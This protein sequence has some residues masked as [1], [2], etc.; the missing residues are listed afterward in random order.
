MDVAISNI[1]WS[2][3]DRLPIYAALCDRGVRG[4]EFAPGLLFHDDRDPF[5]PSP[6][7]LRRVRTELDAA[8][9]TLVSMQSLLYGTTDAVLFGDEHQ[10][11]TFIESITRAIGLAGL[12]AVPNLVMGS[13]KNRIR[14]DDMSEDDAD[15]I[16]VDVFRQLGDVAARHGTV[17]ALEPNPAEYGTNFL[18]TFP[19]AKAFRDRVGHPSV[20]VNLDLG[21]LHMTG[22]FGRL[23]EFLQ[24]ALDAV[25]HLHVSRP[26]LSPAPH[27][28][29]EAASIRRAVERSDY[30]GWVSIE[31]RE[32]PDGVTGVLAAVDRILDHPM[33]E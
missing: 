13:P 26:H 12:L 5:A 3:E 25:S 21:A 29:D 18:T 17:L 30:S 28:T 31:M 19:D 9:L 23:D 10:R 16:A 4:L 11:R 15:R 32:P 2:P 6:A 1:A 22:D 33:E 24:G 14:P 8:Q 7:A 20:T 27:D